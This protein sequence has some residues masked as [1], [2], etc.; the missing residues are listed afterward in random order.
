MSIC[1]ERF[2]RTS[3]RHTHLVGLDSG[4]LLVLLHMLADAFGELLQSSLGDGL[5]HLGY[6]DDSVG[7]VTHET[8]HSWRH[9]QRGPNGR[10][11]GAH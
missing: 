2:H 3:N 9:A 7:V 4:Y 8:E 5:G 6:F 11:N 10:A 1:H